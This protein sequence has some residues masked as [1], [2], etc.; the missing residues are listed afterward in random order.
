MPNRSYPQE[1]VYR[2]FVMF[3]EYLSYSEISKYDGTP[4]EETISRWDK[5]G[6]GTEGY[7]WRKIREMTAT[8]RAMVSY[9]RE[10]GERAKKPW[11]EKVDE[12]SQDLIDVRDKIMQAIDDGDVKE[13]SVSDLTKV[14]KTE[15]MIQGEAQQQT[16]AVSNLTQMLATIVAN[17]VRQN[18]KDQNKADRIL[19]L[20]AQDFEAAR[21]ADGD[22]GTVAEITPGHKK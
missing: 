10:I 15:A 18:L 3:M 17:R 12:M 22:P 1:T 20:I 6:E 13:Y 2:C 8:R 7:P 19:D 5:Q 21:A 11:D 16:K 4:H 9:D 14:M